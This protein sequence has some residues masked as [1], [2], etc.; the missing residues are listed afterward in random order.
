V[1]IA[2]SKDQLEQVVQLSDKSWPR[3]RILSALF[4]ARIRVI[5]HA[6][7]RL[8][9][10]FGGQG[11]QRRIPIHTRCPIFLRNPAFNHPFW[12]FPYP[13]MSAVLVAVVSFLSA[14]LPNTA[15]VAPVAVDANSPPTYR[16]PG[17]LDDYGSSNSSS[18]SR[19]RPAMPRKRRRASDGS[20]RNS[21]AYA[22]SYSDRSSIATDGPRSDDSSSSRANTDRTH[23]ST[24]GEGSLPHEDHRPP[25]PSP[26]FSLFPTLQSAPSSP[27]PSC[28]S[29]QSSHFSHPDL[30]PQEPPHIPA[31]SAVIDGT[32]APSLLTEE[33]LAL[34]EDALLRYEAASLLRP[35][36]VDLF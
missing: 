20:S 16:L 2:S 30:E 3:P 23:P 15:V 18:A 1:D 12:P 8:L 19:S 7:I 5:S 34:G 29:I 32:S 9:P 14:L 6:V 25:S 10:S 35:L 33:I 27:C 31:R 11:G 17:G 26:F 21:S 28:S 13:N 4:L 24:P 22:T 36:E